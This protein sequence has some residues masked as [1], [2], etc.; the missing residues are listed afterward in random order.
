MLTGEGERKGEGCPTLEVNLL[1]ER[2]RDDILQSLRNNHRR[3]L[4]DLDK[5]EQQVMTQRTRSFVDYLGLQYTPFPS[6]TNIAP[7]PHE[8][9]GKDLPF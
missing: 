5:N 1:V 2:L 4:G 6:D 8:V 9:S 7:S 3:Y